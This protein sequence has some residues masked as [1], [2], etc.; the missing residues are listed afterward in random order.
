MHK[1]T[2]VDPE[3]RRFITGRTCPQV[4]TKKGLYLYCNQTCRIIW[5]EG[6]WIYFE[7]GHVIGL[8]AQRSA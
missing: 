6:P 5:E 3:A 1:V 4:N 8:W 7:A 2:E